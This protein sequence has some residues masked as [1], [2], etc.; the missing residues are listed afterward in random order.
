MTRVGR[1]LERALGWLYPERCELCSRIGRPAV[2]DECLK[3]FPMLAQP[4]THYATGAALDLSASAYAFDGRAA[5]AVKRLK[6]SRATALASP[7]ARLVAKAKDDLPLPEFDLIVP[8]PIHYRRRCRRGFNQSELLCAA[9]DSSTVHTSILKRIR[10]TR[11]QV[12][13]AKAERLT[14]LRGAFAAEPKVRGKRVL[15]VDDVT[16]TGGTA[17]ACAEALKQAGA[18]YVGVLTLCGERDQAS[19]ESRP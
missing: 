9:F 14:N 15:L 18:T 13:L 4:V 16:T 8:V 12:G 1:I 2:C 3:E 5:T 19:G 7:L 17:I 11:P 10:S 6:Y